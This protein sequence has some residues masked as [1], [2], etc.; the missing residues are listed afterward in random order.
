MPALLA[1]LPILLVI[2][3][4]AVLNMKSIISLPLGLAIAVIIAVTYWQMNIGDVL[5]YSLYGVFRALD[6]ILIVFGAILILNTLKSSGAMGV[7]SDGFGSI[8]KDRRVQIIIIG[9][10]FGAFIEGVAG[11]GTPAALAAPL[12]VGLGFPAL[13]AATITLVLNSTPVAFGAVGVPFL[14]AVSTV[15]G[16]VAAV[17][18]E[19]SVFQ[20]ELALQVGIIH[21]IVGTFLPALAIAIMTL[22]FGKARSLKPTLAVLPFAIFGGLAFTIPYFLSALVLTA[23]LPS[24][25]GGLIGLGVTVTA[26]RRGFLIPKDTWDFPGAEAQ[27]AAAREI[28]NLDDAKARGIGMFRAWFPYL[29]IA[30]L[31]VLTRAPAV[32]LKELLR[33]VI[34]PFPNLFGVDLQFKF[35]PIY[36]PG[37]V[38]FVLV[39]LASHLLFRMKRK[40][41]VGAWRKSFKQVAPA[42]AALAAGIAMVQLM[43]NSGV[44][45]RA[46]PSMLSVLARTMADLSGR[47]FVVISPFI[48]ALG[49][50]MA[51]SNTVSNILFSSLQFETAGFLG[52]PQVTI[53]ALQVV[54]GGIGNMICINN[55]VAVAATVGIV[56]VEGKIIRRNVVPMTIYALLATAIAVLLIA[57]A[58]T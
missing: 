49:S 50:F 26:A 20:S 11:F 40:Q 46:L 22:V 45:A 27:P 1:F 16:N 25:I 6:I 21:G 37:V 14:A 3:M 32:G 12:L 9:W 38:P 58:R 41:I 2:I 19:L 18:Q 17:G 53:V 33:K 23:E 54:G 10:L 34:V 35:L 57:A 29:L 47:G 56:G 51:G 8:S 15:S 36:N 31:L 28:T 42:A 39:A 7:I 13:A 48:G 24:I 5:G 43:V 44:N 4:M 30:G 52:L 55:I